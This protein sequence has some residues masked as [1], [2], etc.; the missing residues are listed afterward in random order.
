[1]EQQR[2][3][4]QQEAIERKAQQARDAK[5]MAGKQQTVQQ[6]AEIAQQ[7]SAEAAIQQQFDTALEKGMQA[8][9]QKGYITAEYQFKAALKIKPNN[10]DAKAGLLHAM[11]GAGKRA[12]ALTYANEQLLALAAKPPGADGRSAYAQWLEVLGDNGL[13][14]D[15]EREQLGHIYPFGGGDPESAAADFP[16]AN[17]KSVFLPFVRQ[18]GSVLPA[19]RADYAD[20]R[21]RE[22]DELWQK[23]DAGENAQTVQAYLDKYP[24]GSHAIA[25]RERLAAIRYAEAKRKREETAALQE[26]E[27]QR[28]QAEAAEAAAKDPTYVSQGGL[29]WMPVTTFAM[30][31]EW[32]EADSYC[33]N[34]TIRGQSGW[35]LPTKDEL[36]ALYAS[37]AMKNQG[38]RLGDTWSSTSSG[39][40]EHYSVSLYGGYV[41]SFS[42]IL[43]KNKYVTCVR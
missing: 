10:I 15:A 40:F 25:A 38:W 29:T 33:A 35:R 26:A 31:M 27:L 17:P 23:A 13:A 22:E 18:I 2:Q 16:K 42:G 3:Q 37:G 14:G 11:L 41:S 7:A 19:I 21:S 9:D 20:R 6:A 4:A 8:L 1:M 30:E 32:D 28:K 34:T 12:A 43:T 36:T 24:S 39:F 5:E